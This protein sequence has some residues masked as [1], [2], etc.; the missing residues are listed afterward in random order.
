MKEPRNDSVDQEKQ[1]NPQRKLLP[2]IF[3]IFAEAMIAVNQ[4]NISSVYLPISNEFNQGVYGLGVLTAA[5][6]LSYGLFEI[7]GGILAVRSGPKKLAVFGLTMN[8]IGVIASSFSPQF[9]FLLIFRFLSGVGSAF[10][11]P[12]LLVLVVRQLRGGSEGLG[13]GW[14]V[15]WTSVG[16]ALGLIAWPAFAQA[17]G[18]R[19]SILG[20]GLISVIPLV[21]TAILVR[22]NYDDNLAVGGGSPRRLL[23]TIK[24]IIRNR[25]L[26]FI[27]LAL[28]GAGEGFAVLSN[29]LVY[30]LEQNFGASPSLAGFVTAISS[31]VP[32][33]V[34]PFVGRAHDRVRRLKVYFLL[35]SIAL[36]VGVGILA[37]HNFYLVIVA[38]IAVGF[39]IGIFFTLGFALAKNSSQK[40]YESLGIAW[41]D[42]FSLVGSI[43]APIYFSLVVLGSGYPVAWVVASIASFLPILPILLLYREN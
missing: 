37:I 26:L 14:T 15:G 6:Y 34:S 17:E 22:P 5:L 23:V 29:F 42:S 38:G 30:Y 16:S 40:E 7:P 24:S 33:F 31:M 4:T 10:A 19:T 8:T 11:F 35:G 3:L 36:M 1:R 27:G 28:F 18:W 12:T 2:L 13:S 32:I 41:V 43:I 25:K 20:A 39:A 21:A 9:D